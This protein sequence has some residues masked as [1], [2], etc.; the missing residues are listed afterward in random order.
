MVPPKAPSLREEIV[1]GKMRGEIVKGDLQLDGPVREPALDPVLVLKKEK[2]VKPKAEP[3]T[4]KVKGE[5]AV[6]KGEKPAELV[7]NPFL[8]FKQD[9]LSFLEP[10]KQTDLETMVLKANVA[11]YNKTPLLTDNEYDIV[12]EYLERKY[13]DSQVLLEIGAPIQKNKATLPYQMP[14]M[15]KIKPDTNALST[16]KSIYTGPYVL[17]CKLDGVSGLYTT[18]GD[19]PKLYTRGNGTIGQDISHLLKYLKLPTEQ[20]I[21]VR[22]EFIIPKAVFEEKYKSDFANPRNLVAGIINS[23]TVDEK[24]RDLHFVTYEVME[25]VLKPSEQLYILGRLKFEVVQHQVVQEISNEALSALLL[26]WRSHH[27]YEIDGVI[28]TNDKIYARTAGNPDHAFAFKMVISDQVA[29]VK[30]VDVIWTPSKNGYLK[31]RVRVEP[32][33]LSGVTIEYATGFNGKFIEENKIGVGALIEIIR[34]GD[35]IPYIKSVI[36]PAERA[37]MPAVSY[38]WTDTHVDIILE[39]VAEDVVVLEKNITAFFV[40][41]EVEGLS[42]GNVKRLIAAG[43]DS[44]AKIIHMKKLDYENVEGF[45]SKLTDKI[46]T[47]IHDRLGKASLIEIMAASNVLGRGLGERKIKPIMDAFPIILTSNET[48]S[49]KVAKLL[50]VKGIG[51][52]NAATFVSNIPA[53]LAFMQECGLEHRMRGS[54][55]PEQENVLRPVNISH[56]LYGKKVVMT[57]VRDKQIIEHLKQVGAILEDGIKKDTFV[58]IVKSK[59]DVSNKTK[60]AVEHAIPIM[61]PEEFKG[62]YNIV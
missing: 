26:D 24:I 33:R 28:V 45:K 59:E 32:V 36:V 30:V 60:F 37:K 1:E 12:K 11:Y 41:I 57:K 34:S 3:K 5:K 2:V 15:D 27:Q 42:T 4:R 8:Q 52:E 61:T 58:L 39:N 62:T 50:T 44:V 16:W 48:N 49:E 18:M 22:G 40:G 47:S 17:S 6:A 35:V 9:G 29:E 13:P 43:F 53:F 54:P 46:Y 31:P 55:V 56:P 38:V 10:L 7:E 25:P 20:K 21:V 19:T 14:S 23:K 51:K